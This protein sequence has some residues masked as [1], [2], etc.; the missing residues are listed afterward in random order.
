LR[1]GVSLLLLKEKEMEDEVIGVL[2][3]TPGGAGERGH[4]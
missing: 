2:L 3:S 1:R 4:E